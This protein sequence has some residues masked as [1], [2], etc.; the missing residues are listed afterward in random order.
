MPAAAAAKNSPLHIMVILM[1]NIQLP[2]FDFALFLSGIV[3]GLWE[4]KNET[5]LDKKVDNRNN[6]YEYQQIVNGETIITDG[7]LLYQHIVQ[8]DLLLT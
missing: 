3:P 6:N 2:I 8:A 7:V 5:I 1:S 4:A